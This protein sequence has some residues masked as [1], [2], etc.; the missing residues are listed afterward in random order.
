MPGGVIAKWA[1]E[2]PVL[3]AQELAQN[4]HSSTSHTFWK[5]LFSAFAS[6][7]VTVAVREDEAVGSALLRRQRATCSWHTD[8]LAQCARCRR[9]PGG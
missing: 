1:G 2:I 3:D 6:G 5:F 4:L 7:Q 9:R 8:G